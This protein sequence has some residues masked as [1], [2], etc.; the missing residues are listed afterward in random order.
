MGELLGLRWDDIDWRRGFLH[1]QRGFVRGAFTSTKSGRDRTVDL[2][3]QTRAELRLWRRKQAAFWLKRGLER[4]ALVF[5]SLARTPH[6]HSKVRKIWIALLK[7]ADLRFRNM[8]SMRHAFISLLI[9]AGTS[10]AYVQKQ[11][12][13]R[14]MDLTLNVYGHLVPGAGRDAVDQLDDEGSAGPHGTRKSAQ[15]LGA[16]S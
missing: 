7:K 10:V 2:S 4:P 15:L 1:V 5:P 14:S 3:T 8:H 16:N 6:D 12:G 11:A 13:H 9:Q